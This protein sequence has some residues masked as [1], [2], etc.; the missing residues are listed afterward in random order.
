MPIPVPIPVLVL[1]LVL[2]L[3]TTPRL[4]ALPAGVS[5]FRRRVHEPL[6]FGVSTGRWPTRR[7]GLSIDRLGLLIAMSTVQRAVR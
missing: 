5:T 1:V 2:V 4:A 3:A 7:C 6:N